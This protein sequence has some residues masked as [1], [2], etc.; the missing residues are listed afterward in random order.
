[1]SA[2]EEYVSVIRQKH[3]MNGRQDPIKE[4][5]ILTVFNAVIKIN[6]FTFRWSE[7]LCWCGFS[8]KW[9]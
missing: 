7:R 6:F 9:K 3:E 8:K 1:M 4:G 2:N 5:N